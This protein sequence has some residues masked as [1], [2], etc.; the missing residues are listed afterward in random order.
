ME[1]KGTKREVAHEYFKQ[2]QLGFQKAS[3]TEE[4]FYKGYVWFEK[5]VNTMK[6]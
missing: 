1:F 2:G 6:C 5:I 4:A 3:D